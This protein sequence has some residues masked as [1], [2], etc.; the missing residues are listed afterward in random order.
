MSTYTVSTK[1]ES[2]VPADNLLYDLTIYRMDSSKKKHYILS[3]ISKQPVQSNYETLKHQTSE[4]TD[5]TTT[6]YMVEIMLYRKHLGNISPALKEPFIRMYTLDDL[7]A[8]KA[9]SEKKREN[10]CYF[11][12]TGQ[13]ELE[14]KGDNTIE[15]RI[16]VPE[17]QFIAKEYPVGSSRDPFKKDLLEFELLQRMDHF[18]YPNQR[19]TSLCGPAAL[20]YSLLIDRPDIY[21]QSAKELWQYG[22]TN[23][24]SL[25]ISPS[26]GCKNPTGAFYDDD[27]REKVS[28]LDWVTL[29]SIR[30]SENAI[31]SYS[32]VD[33]QV[34]GITMWGALAE[35]FEKVGYIKIFSNISF[36]HS[37]LQD[38]VTLNNYIEQGY[39]VVSLI[40]AG[41]LER[42]GSG[43]SSAKN[44][45]IVWESPVLGDSGESLS[46]Q[47]DK[48]T[49]VNVK[50]FSW[51]TVET[52]VRPNHSLEYFLKHTFGALVFKKVC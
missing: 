22:M 41:M 13:A 1:I 5:L 21:A 31:M 43:S 3:G 27:G 20:F 51:G 10:A 50:A 45:W 8:G 18:D 17:R 28:G 36:S 15:L 52:Q 48:N 11:E 47:T 24:G 23:I 35:W 9:C 37:N 42:F 6:I 12:S 26:K 40:S 49:I 4:T 25:K 33:D 38:I 14:S 16:S 34:A 46:L 44:H 19:H 2:N 7:I 32:E 30:D 29:A 39:R